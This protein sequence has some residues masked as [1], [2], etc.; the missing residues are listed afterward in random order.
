MKYEEAVNQGYEAI[1]SYTS[2]P[3]IERPAL[4]RL[5]RGDQVVIVKR[6]YHTEV[7]YM[8]MV[9]TDED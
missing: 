7:T 5:E 3:D 4:T 2:Y 8:L 6:Y 9:K 1:G